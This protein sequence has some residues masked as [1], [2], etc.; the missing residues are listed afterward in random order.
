[1]ARVWRSSCDNWRSWIRPPGEC[2]ESSPSPCALGELRGA[3]L[4][5]PLALGAVV[6]AYSPASSA[7]GFARALAHE[8]RGCAGV[9]AWVARHY[10]PGSPAAAALL[11]QPSSYPDAT[12]AAAISDSSVRFP[13][14]SPAR[15]TESSR[16][17]SPFGSWRMRSRTLDQSHRAA[18][19][20][21]ATVTSKSPTAG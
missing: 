11:G 19:P 18:S 6:R 10:A 21:G 1:M 12:I 5:Y 2:P 15:R 17:A 16:T 13:A 3:Q 4:A 9:V 20:S 8:D 14:A 7:A